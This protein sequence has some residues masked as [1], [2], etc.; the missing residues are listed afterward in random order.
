[1]EEKQFITSDL[2]LSAA[3]CLLLQTT[4]QFKVENGR[5]LFVF[6]ITDKL[7]CAIS[8]FNCGIQ[9]NA[10]EYAQMIKRM[11]AEMLMRKGMGK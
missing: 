9:L 11:R 10:I 1:M 2:Y 4:P 3:L 8:E 5:T 6:A 7:H